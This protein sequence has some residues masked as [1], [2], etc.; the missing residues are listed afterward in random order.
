M[1]RKK[2]IS[3]VLLTLAALVIMQLPM[4]EADAATSASDFQIQGS[5]LTK[6]RGKEKNVSIPDTVQIIGEGAF[7]NDVNIELVVVPNSVK[8]IEPYAFWGCD[9]LDTVVLGKGLSEVGDY[10]FTKCTGLQQITI[11]STVTSIGI[12]AFEDCGNLTDVTIPPETVNI[13]ETAF[14]GCYQ[15][16][17][18]YE[19]GSA[20]AKYAE[21]FYERQK[22][23]PGYQKKIPGYQEPSSGTFSDIIKQIISTPMPAPE[24]PTSS[25]EPSVPEPLPTEVV[26]TLL[27]STQIVGNRA[28]VFMS[29]AR[30]KVFGAG[31]G[32]GSAQE[33]NTDSSSGEAG[34]DAMGSDSDGSNSSI[35]K[36][37]V[38]DGRVVADQAYYRNAELGEM[39]LADGIVEIGQFAYSRS[40][41]TGIDFPQGLEQI[42]YGA[43]YHC[44]QLED[45]TLP[46]SVMCVEPKAFDH[47]PWIDNFLNG[48]AGT[49]A[50]GDFLVSGGVLVAYRG[51]DSEVTV[52]EGVRVIA[53]EAFRGHE[54]IES[55]SFP[56]SLLVVG[57]GAFEGCTSLGRITFGKNVEEIKDRA[58]LG[59]V[60]REVPVPASLEKVGLKAFG[61]AVI[62]YEGR[63]A[64]YT[65]ETSATRLSNEEY[66]VYN[67]TGEEAAGVA[68]NGLAG[69]SA[70]LDGA[71]RSYSL[72]VKE[73]EDVSIMEAA[74]QRSFQR[75]L[76]ADMIVYGMELTDAS[77]I[78]LKK[79]G[80]QTL[81]VSVPVPEQL[82]GQKVI[83]VTLDRNGQMEPQAV[84][85]T[86]VDGAEV[87]RFELS[88]ISTIG[89]YRN[90][91]GNEMQ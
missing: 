10:A 77:G 46:E 59:N 56:D 61:T 26:G 32:N 4:A 15:L 48:N 24:E 62:A 55:V 25:E 50:A 87:L 84:E 22:E 85:Q 1:K 47:T 65:Y 72:T 43:F 64:E 27:G 39:S 17:I 54:E 83:L 38:V 88:Y 90:E 42:D 45:V 29:N 8:Q 73:A 86:V 74:F 23:M 81:S 3:S 79:L 21:D 52:P 58:F 7:E 40:S 82:Q 75:Q 30:L 91:A 31:S 28:V 6:Y 33:P 80:S 2:R 41:L 60:M 13:H 66:R 9:N 18:H 53:A 68:V 67:N 11:P 44:A 5:T 35:P 63:E 37:R 76:P 34:T 57:E 12:E 36:Y 20:A 49:A 89:I 69:A 71:E 19:E 16:T 51:N 70:S 14:D 78:P